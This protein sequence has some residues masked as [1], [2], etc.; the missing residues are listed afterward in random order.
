MR[1]R[2][3]GSQLNGGGNGFVRRLQERLPAHSL[4]GRVARGT[5][6]TL[7]GGIAVQ[8]AA[9][10][11]SVLAARILG[12]AGFGELGMIRS[13]VLMFGVLGGNG[14]G[15]AATKYVAQ[16]RVRD[17]R[18]AGRLIEMLT[19][20]SIALGGAA[21]L[22]CL[23]LAVPIAGRVL[24]AESLAVPLRIGALVLLLNVLGGV[25]L[26]AISGFEAFRTVAKVGLLD[27]FLNLLLV[28][29]G[30]WRWG[31]AGA[32]GGS[33]AAALAGY[34]VKRAALR[35]IC[36]REGVPV[37]RGDF[38]SEV[39]VLWKFALPAVLIGLCIQPFEWGARAML[40]RQPGGFAEL[41]LFT[42][43]WS[44]GQFVLFLPAQVSNPLVS[45]LSNL[46][47][48]GDRVR[49][50]KTVRV[51]LALTAGL[52]FAA[53]APLLLFPGHILRAYGS[54]FAS[55]RK[56]LVLVLLAYAIA[57]VS[58]LLRSVLA[59]TG[60]MWWQMFHSL[61]WGI[62]MVGTFF[63]FGAGDAAGLALAHIAAYGVVIAAQGATAFYAIRETMPAPTATAGRA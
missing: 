47:A 60:R 44:W 37:S 10:L 26:G 58:G 15:M 33:A 62:T 42:A 59:A 13:T 20:A 25:Q 50:L 56:V 35:G 8:G 19:R 53:A 43:A 11:A 18:R 39:P 46:H 5:A 7:A 31:I 54:E 48:D 3:Q 6:W 49:V 41:G 4:R 52:G 30:A 12:K 61:V 32:L 28:P 57:P 29:L 21:A 2:R 16:H 38:R 17:P 1:R 40:S 14:L 45:I 55:G 34:F 27:G 24:N 63:L 9:L 23:L 22:V 36:R 51:S